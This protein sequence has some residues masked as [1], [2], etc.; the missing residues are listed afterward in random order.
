MFCSPP[1]VDSFNHTSCW[2]GEMNSSDLSLTF[3]LLLSS[4]SLKLLVDCA[5]KSA[6]DVILL[7]RICLVSDQ[8]YSYICRIQAKEKSST[9]SAA[10]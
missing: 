1:G 10:A 4:D 8:S 7:R 5:A 9:V 6:Q 3:A 2:V